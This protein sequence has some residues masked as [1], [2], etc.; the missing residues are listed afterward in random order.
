MKNSLPV[1]CFAEFFGTF[2]FIS[3]GLASVAVLVLGLSDI[4]Y[5][6]MAACWGV[7]I[8]LAIYVVG[9]VSG[10]HMNPA[11]T[12]SLAVWGGFDKKNV[13]PYIVAQ[14]IGAFCAAALV[15]TCFQEQIVAF[16]AA[17]G[18]IRDSANGGGSAGMYVTAAGASVSTMTAFLV[19]A[20]ITC[21][22]V[23]VI[24]ATTD[25]KNPAA[26]GLGLPALAI[27]AIVLFCGIAFG[28]LTGFAMNPARDLGPRLFLMVS[29]W[30][31]AALGNGSYWL[32]VPIV[33]TITGGQIAG[34]L[35]TKVICR[36][37]AAHCPPEGSVACEAPA[38]LID[39][40]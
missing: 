9:G 19:E 15:Y 29:G 5:P 2:L 8:T 20:F 31:Q 4:N 22:L 28:P 38:D 37:I 39:A 23:L 6:W 10:A 1:L 13:L 14:I 26:P 18:I 3:I 33:A 7:A 17:K 24:Y 32:I 11:V 36:G 12:L 21:L 16:E 40:A 27:G 25:V 35:Y 34:F 30:G